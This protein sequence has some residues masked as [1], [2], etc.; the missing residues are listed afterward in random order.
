MAG[1]VLH[2]L[3]LRVKPLVP[4]RLRPLATRLAG[5]VLTRAHAGDA[6]SCPCCGVS[7][8]RFAAYPSLYC[9]R[10]GSYERHRLLALLFARRPDLLAPP[11]RLLQVSPDRP[12]EPLLARDGIDRVSIDLDDTTVNLQM[13][14]ENLTF[15]DAS[16]DAVLALHV[17]DAVG[18]Q[19]R[20]LA[21]LHRVLRPSGLAVFQ[22]A[23]L[24]QPRLVADLAPAGLELEAIVRAA[25]FGPEAILKHALLEA[26]ETY[27]CR[28]PS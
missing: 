27:V 22:V 26:E 4:H 18:D 28:K 8:K 10:C 16:F 17:L 2:R 7:L 5:R 14:V 3:R 25:D 24:E 23:V 1:L 15:E 19:R 21:E 20:A 13:D 12:L 9:P 6:V 11:L